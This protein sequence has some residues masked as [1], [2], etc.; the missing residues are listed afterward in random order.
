M[1]KHLAFVIQIVLCLLCFSCKAQIKTYPILFECTERLEDPYGVCT[2]I[3]TKGELYEYD[4]KVQE[5]SMIDRCSIS[6]IRTDFYWFLIKKTN[7]VDINYHHFDTMM[8]TVN[9]WNKHLLGIISA[10]SSRS[11]YA[12]WREYIGTTV[13][14]YKSDVKYWEIINE[15]NLRHKNPVWS[16]FKATDYA[17]LLKIGST[18]I[19]EKDH[20][21][22]IVFTGIG[23]FESEFVDTVYKTG[24]ADYFDIMNVHYYH[25]NQYEPE[26]FIEIYGRLY[27]KMNKHGVIKPVWLT[28]CG[29]PTTTEGG[30]SEEV[31]AQKLPRI[32][33][34]SFASGVDKVFWYNFRSN[35][36]NPKDNE[37]FF[38]LCHK[39]YVP[40][41]SFYTY[42]TL[43]R[44]CPAGS[45][46]PILQK[47]GKVYIANWVRT[48]GK[49]V[50]G[51]WTSKGHEKILLK[52]KDRHTF[53]D[54]YGKKMK[55][56]RNKPIDVHTSITYIVGNKKLEIGYVDVL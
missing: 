7:D 3:N 52:M 55:L 30:A 4:T 8:E 25:P 17:D 32:F 46:R 15:A 43:I 12:D 31:Q 18:E 40:K 44:F 5:L 19:R 26:S 45:T 33:L 38:G 13:D 49:R 37:C 20:N 47:V 1:L 34:L 24:T 16:W 9:T 50:Y 11:Q 54:I 14:R 53:Y 2:H 28:E 35:E 51:L 6:W 36:K 10:P 41:P 56:S 23:D 48:D 42:K 29:C 39:D 22:K 27:D 21:A